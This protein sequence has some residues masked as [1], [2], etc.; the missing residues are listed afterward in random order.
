MYFCFGK[1]NVVF[2]DLIQTVTNFNQITFF[3][4]AITKLEK[5]PNIVLKFYSILAELSKAGEEF[6]DDFDKSKIQQDHILEEMVPKMNKEATKLI[7][8]YKI[9]DLVGKEAVDL[10]DADAVKV[11]KTGIEDLPL[12][13][14]LHH[15]FLV[16]TLQ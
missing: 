15:L 11:L 4:S 7:D 10:L 1:Q 5:K 12:V 14:L 3:V 2:P 8:V 16:K 9:E 13:Q 6:E